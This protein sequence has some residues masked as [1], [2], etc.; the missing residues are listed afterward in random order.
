MATIPSTGVLIWLSVKPL[1]RI[2]I[3][4]IAGFL[5]IKTRLMEPSG[6]RACSVIMLYVTLPSLLFSKVV[7]SFNSDN[8]SQL[9]PLFLTAFFYILLSGAFGIIW[10]ALTPT[11]RRFRYGILAGYAFGN[12]GDLPTAV[13]QTLAL[14]APF[15]GES[16]EAIAIAYIS[17]F[18]LTVNLCMWPFRGLEVVRWDYNTNVDPVQEWQIEQGERGQVAKWL[19]RIRRGRPLKSDLEEA[20]ASL[21]RK[22]RAASETLETKKQQ[23]DEEMRT[24]MTDALGSDPEIQVQLRKVES[25]PIL[26]AVPSHHSVPSHPSTHPSPLIRAANSVWGIVKSTASPPVIS[27]LLSLVIALVP[28]LKTLFVY[29]PDTT[30]HPLA[31]DGQPPLSILFS[32][33]QFIGY[34][35]VPLGLTVLGASLAKIKVPRPISRLPFT[36]IGAMALT[37][38]CLLPIIGYFFVFG[39]SR[40]SGGI[41]AHD[42]HVLRFTLAYMSCMP[43]GTIQ[44]AYSQL[45]AP[46]G[47]DNNS[48]LL[49]AYILAQYAVYVFASPILTAVALTSIF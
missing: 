1:I 8:I 12:Y 42:N 45:F 26:E 17:I 13:I 21:K 34:A 14:S 11:P 16:D 3:P 9:G 31:I 2:A 35:S 38:L 30:W 48:E 28:Q 7:P 47:Q 4:T 41:V 37:R 27:L 15:K 32:T 46:P 19:W 29:S 49:S 44:L 5:L 22:H 39:L 43:T 40:E 23:A 20:L 36:S 24:A 6:T 25:I 33:A 10:R 18:I